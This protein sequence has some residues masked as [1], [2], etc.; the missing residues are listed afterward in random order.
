MTPERWREI[1]R[2]FH[3]ALER[4]ASERAAFLNQAC[5]GDPVLR[6]EVESLLKSSDEAGSF[7]E[8]PAL[9]V[10]AGL[11]RQDDAVSRDRSPDA[12][13]PVFDR[14]PGETV[15]AHGRAPLQG[16][17]I[18]H[19]HLLE[20]LGAGGM[21]EV[22]KAEDVTLHRQVAL[23]FLSV[24][25]VYDRRSLAEEKAGAHR[26]P[27]QPDPDALARFQREARA[28]A[29]LNHP[30]IC[31]IYEIGEHEG[32][33][34]I[35]MEL[36]EGETL[37]ERLAKPL[38]SGPSPAGGRGEKISDSQPSPLGRGWPREAG[39]GEGAQAGPIP[40]DQLLD[41]AIQIA[42][43]LDAA[44]QKGI[45]HRDIKPA[46]I[47]LVARG[48]T[49]QPKILDFGL[50]KLTSGLTPGPSP[51]GGRGEKISDLQPSPLGRGSP[52]AVGRG[53]GEGG[54][55]TASL[56]AWPAGRDAA[57]LTSPG[58]AMGT[59]AYMSPE[60]A[61][62]EEVDART[63]LFSFGA[64]LY[65][66]A[67][68][69]R[70]FGG[71]S[72]AVIFSQILKEDPPPI[73]TV[74]SDLRV[75]PGEGAH[76][77]AP[78]QELQRI[79]TKCLEKDRD[80]RYQVASEIRA[81]LK[82]LKRDTESGRAAATTSGVGAHGRAPLRAHGRDARAATG[83]HRAQLQ[84]VLPWALAAIAVIAAVGLWFFVFQGKP[85]MTFQIGQIER[86][87]N[88][89]DVQ[90]AAISPDGRYVAYV[91]GAPEGQS[92]WL[93]Q[94]ATGS[95]VPILPAAPVNYSGLTFT[96]DGNF[97]Y[98]VSAAPAASSGDVYLVP[99][100]G[101]EPGKIIGDALGKVAVSPEGGQ[102]AFVRG[103]EARGNELVVA[104]SGGGNP[105]VIASGNTAQMV[106]RADPA[107]SP[108]GK[109]IALGSDSAGGT[110]PRFLVTVSA[111][112]GKQRIVWRTV[113]W[114][115]SM[116][117]LPD[118]RGLIVAASGQGQL[119]QTQLWQVSY[120]SGAVRRITHDLNA[121]GMLTLTADGETLGVI[122]S[123]TDS[124]IWIAPFGKLDQPRQVT[125]AAQG[126]E[127]LG[128]LDWP[129]GDQIFY[130]SADSGSF[131]VWRMDADGS[132]QANL[133]NPHDAND[134]AFS[135]C[136]ASNDIVFASDREGGVNLWR[137]RR[138]GTDLF[139]LTH[140]SSD[141]GPPACSP[142]GKWAV[143]A[144]YA[145]G[146]PELWRVPVQGGSVQ[147]VSAQ[148]C[149]SPSISPDGRWIACVSPGAGVSKIAVIPFNGGPAAKVFPV[150]LRADLKFSN[151]PVPNFGPI[152]W[153]PGGRSI[154][155]I[156]NVHGV[157]NLW[158]QPLAG[159]P[160]KQ[161]TRFQSGRIF[162]FAWSPKGDLAL[163]RGSSSSDVVLIKQPR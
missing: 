120:P 152:R 86:L 147:Q 151:A 6:D 150:Q 138:D 158:V 75:R 106:F 114:I 27:L 14:R 95:D 26:A 16:A 108:D 7:I 115:S 57:H 25:A 117:W 53:E 102:I 101:G 125:S 145:T 140:G 83:A 153:V 146:S 58:V 40:V 87:T 10:A 55:P 90:A 18:S 43:A 105:H 32:Q 148:P 100:L 109:I 66:T 111:N 42:D 128:T 123:Q 99:S 33:P 62:G 92:I 137:I 46:N 135:V 103:N 21:G 24:A 68:G 127:G 162:S 97:L 47:F 124:N 163:A 85:P 81:D 77:G 126:S 131:A 107:W 9:D 161:L 118:G 141:H 132:H 5:A 139:H 121:H 88:F 134:R 38:T 54:T 67:T 63:D 4:T 70:A 82:R 12:L 142:D 31:T 37:K 78:L 56:P 23:K 155:F 154:A 44:H 61:R 144:S 13:G 91:R 59:V 159:G 79:V 143:Y 35:A 113:G 80:L 157:S 50:A 72:T 22:Y 28:A 112:G 17:T 110:P 11:P 65:E 136:P 71:N 130:S 122:E 29:A 19:Y 94:T 73:T 156:N 129:P 84:R 30:N 64:V 2:I 48:S 20:K 52:D 89:G 51:A 74:G 119:L 41:W 1:E 76:T 45:T 133:T 96:L 116:A 49:F 36:L 34:F 98:Y 60:Q 160:P 69:R 39:P 93:R 15:G 8:H 104:N 149:H 3:E